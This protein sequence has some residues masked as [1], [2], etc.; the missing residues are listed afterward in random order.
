MINI[1]ILLIIFCLVY[2]LF[3]NTF[4]IGG[5]VSD[6]IW[7]QNIKSLVLDNINYRKVEQSTPNLQIVSMSLKVG[8]EIGM[9]RHSSATQYIQVQQGEGIATVKGVDYHL[10]NDSAIIIPPNTL[11]NVKN[12]GNEPLKLYTI[13][14]PPEHRQGLIQPE[15]TT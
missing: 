12:V 13:Y 9:E 14:S 1:L 15:K 4:I 11:H 10:G 3:Y 5:N 7:C 2:A 8:E 6:S